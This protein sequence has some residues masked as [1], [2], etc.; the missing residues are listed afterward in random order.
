MGERKRYKG[1]EV[2]QKIA[3]KVEKYGKLSRRIGV[4]V[5]KNR[6][7]FEGKHGDERGP[8]QVDVIVCRGDNRL[9]FT[10]E[11]AGQIASLLGKL[12]PEAAE[13]AKTCREEQEA[14]KGK[15]RYTPGPGREVMSP[16]KTQRTKAKKKKKV[17]GA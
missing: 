14:W 12:V 3:E 6:P 10:A 7:L 9:S 1:R 2:V 15:M 11:E 16:G 4:I 5:E 17:S 8:V 13:A